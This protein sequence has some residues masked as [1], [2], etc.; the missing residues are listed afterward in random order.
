M[1]QPG[2][3]AKEG[4]DMR[5]LR[6]QLE[7]TQREVERRTLRLVRRTG[8]DAH[9]VSRAYLRDIELGN[10]RPSSRK[11]EALAK[12]YEKEF[13]ELLNI[14]LPQI[15]GRNLFNSFPSSSGSVSDPAVEN[16]EKGGQVLWKV[17]KEFTCKT[18]RLLLADEDARVIPAGWHESLGGKH[19]RFAVTGTDDYKMGKLLPGHC[20]VAVDT[21]QKEIEESDE[22]PTDA[23]RPIYLVAM[24]RG[25]VCRWAYKVGD[26]LTL[27]P[28]QAKSDR[29]AKSYKTRS[30]AEILGRVIH[31]WRLAGADAAQAGASL[32]E[33]RTILPDD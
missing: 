2:R 15:E 11:L 6:Q 9:H 10:C 25:Y 20:L 12:T 16:R 33:S 7:L 26:M 8:E 19:I 18:S 17:A 32:K 5:K 21:R 1:E 4:R 29:A 23:H 24:E 14:Y 13:Q 3:W 30:K 22:W 31:A 28:C 27:L